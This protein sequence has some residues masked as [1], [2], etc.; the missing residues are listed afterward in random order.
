MSSRIS[1]LIAAAVGLLLPLLPASAAVPEQA[2]SAAGDRSCTADP[3]SCPAWMPSQSEM[4]SVLAAYFCEAVGRGLLRPG[5]S[6]VVHAETSQVTCAALGPGPGDNFVC[7]GE[8][9]FI[10]ADGRIDA[11]E[12]SPTMHRQDDGR[13]ALYEGDDEHGDPRWHVPLP[14]GASK[15]CAGLTAP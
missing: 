6:R 7:G 9:R 1:L 2:G 11:A 5:V 14:Q 10:G 3:Y 12:F 15:A 8:M 13:Y 4:R